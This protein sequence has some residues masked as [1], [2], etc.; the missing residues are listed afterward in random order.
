M[1][2]FVSFQNLPKSMFIGLVRKIREGNLGM[3]GYNKTNT[4][5]RI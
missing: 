2:K 4:I 3:E 1:K 5:T